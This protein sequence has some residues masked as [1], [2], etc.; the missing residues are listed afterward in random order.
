ML[1]R[2]S[3]ENNPREINGFQYVIKNHWDSFTIRLG[4]SPRRCE[5]NCRR[6]Q[7]LAAVRY[8]GSSA[9]QQVSLQDCAVRSRAGAPSPVLPAPVWHRENIYSSTKWYETV[10]R[11]VIC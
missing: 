3:T 11:M 1:K 8:F 9:A 4:R 10:R 7:V 6:F 2:R 5:L